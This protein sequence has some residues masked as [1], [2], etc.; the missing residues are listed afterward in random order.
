MKLSVNQLGVNQIYF[1]ELHVY[2]DSVTDSGFKHNVLFGIDLSVYKEP[3][4]IEEICR[5]H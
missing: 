5:A 4:M 1:S 3:K 2:T